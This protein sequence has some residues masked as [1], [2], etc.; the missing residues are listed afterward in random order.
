MPHHSIPRDF[1]G[2]TVT[3]AAEVINPFLQV[4]VKALC[5]V[6]CHFRKKVLIIGLNAVS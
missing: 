2:V 1:P 6:S 3:E 5:S 4:F